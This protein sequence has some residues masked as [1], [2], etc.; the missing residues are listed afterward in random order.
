V[1]GNAIV[2][3]LVSLFYFI[4]NKFLG[5]LRLVEREAISDGVRWSMTETCLA[6]TM[7]REE[8]SLNMVGMFLTLTVSKCLHWAIDYR[9]KHLI[10]TEE[11]ISLLSESSFRV[12]IPMAH[13]KYVALVQLLL[14]TDAVALWY[15]VKSCLDDGPSVHLLFGFESMILSL[16]ASNALMLY[17]LHVIDGSVNILVHVSRNLRTKVA[18]ERLAGFWRDKR[19][20]LTLSVDL[21][22]Y[23]GKFLSYLLFFF[24]VFTY[25][26]MPINIFRDLY[27]SFQEFKRKILQFISYRRLNKLMQTKFHTVTNEEELEECGHVCIICRDAMKVGDGAKKLPGCGHIFHP[28][29]LKGWLMQQQTCPTCRRDIVKA[30]RELPT[31]NP[32]P[33]EANAQPDQSPEQEQVPETQHS[34]N[35]AAEP[36]TETTREVKTHDA[37]SE[38]PE[39]SPQLDES[40][41][42]PCFYKITNPQGANVYTLEQRDLVRN[43]PFEKLILCTE[44]KWW[45]PSEEKGEGVGKMMLKMPDGW[46]K[47]KDVGRIIPLPLVQQQ[48]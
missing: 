39:K 4:V 36:T 43:V 31:D 47:D 19:F 9:G 17:A 7:F 15:C 42:F 18:T 45:R 22:T 16:T 12:R 44:I 29:C 5:G 3:L 30:S 6:L 20:T 27:I 41:A 23:A 26:G 48:S 33:P 40:P 34:A 10:Q 24:L 21:F 13:M 35:P 14:A 46:V 25:Y 28:Y 37:L 11:A 8:V 32:P 1:F 38:T 2:A